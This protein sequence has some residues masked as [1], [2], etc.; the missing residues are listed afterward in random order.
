MAKQKKV[1]TYEFADG[2]QEIP[3]SYKAKCNI[4]GEY[5]PIYHKFLE[6]LVKK[7]YKNNFE[8][9]LKHFSKKGAEEKKRIEEGYDDQDKYS[10]NR[11]SDYLIICYKACLET[12]KENFNQ[13][14]IMKTKSEMEHISH[15]FRKHFNRDITKFV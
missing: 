3:A 1:F 5:V 9:F 8:Y 13:Q 11:Y 10:L 7:K 12:L 15:C 14:S 4:T 2:F 6:S